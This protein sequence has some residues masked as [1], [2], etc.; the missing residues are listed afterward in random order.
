MQFINGFIVN[1]PKLIPLFCLEI[2]NA[3][4]EPASLW[5]DIMTD[6]KARGLKTCNLFVIDN[7]TGFDEVIEKVFPLAKY[8][9]VEFID[10]NKIYYFWGIVFINHIAKIS[11][12]C[13][14][15]G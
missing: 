7:L 13:P 1:L 14:E 3:P 15:V 6:L 2:N 4:T 12:A 5:H 8:K 11:G 10:H 9:T